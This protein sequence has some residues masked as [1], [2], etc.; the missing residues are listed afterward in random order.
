MEGVKYNVCI[1]CSINVHTLNVSKHSQ[2]SEG[3]VSSHSA[4]QLQQNVTAA[5]ALRNLQRV[6]DDAEE[7]IQEAKAHLQHR[8]HTNMFYHSSIKRKVQLLRKENFISSCDNETID[9]T[10]IHTPI[11]VHKVHERS[12]NHRIVQTTQLQEPFSVL[13]LVLTNQLISSSHQ[14]K[15]IEIRKQPPGVDVCQTVVHLEVGESRQKH[16][17]DGGRRVI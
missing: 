3:N 10:L 16:L 14:T 6:L 2:R 11:C 5:A 4:Q 12:R 17:R 8:T 1:R 15:F 7:V 9:Q 13:L